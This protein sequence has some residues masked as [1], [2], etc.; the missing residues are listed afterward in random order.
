MLQLSLIKISILNSQFSLEFVDLDVDSDGMGKGLFGETN[1]PGD[2]IKISTL[3]G[4]RFC[5]AYPP[6]VMYAKENIKV[7]FVTT[8]QSKYK[9]R[10]R[11]F[12][13]KY[14]AICYQELSGENGTIQ[15]PNYRV[16]S[17]VPFKCHYHIGGFLSL[18]KKA[19][20]LIEEDMSICNF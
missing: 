1:C 13:I 3:P 8:D 10:G 6:K 15:S 18:R 5:N 16:P 17:A 14:Q 9:S 20:F 4:E 2:Y 12:R 7:E 19:V 11:G